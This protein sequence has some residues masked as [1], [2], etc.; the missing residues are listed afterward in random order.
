MFK[1]RKNRDGKAGKNPLASRVVRGNDRPT[2]PLEDDSPTRPRAE[3]APRRSPGA[4][5]PRSA[6]G[7]G[8]P[9]ASQEPPTRLVTAP[10]AVDALTCSGDDPPVA[11]LLVVSGPGRGALVP[12]GHGMS[13]IGRG[14]DARIRVNFGD[15]QIARKGHAILTYD[16]MGR[17]FYLQHGGGANL[18]YVDGHPV[19]EPVEL[20]DEARLRL[21][22]TEFLFRTLLLP[23]VDESGG[24]SE[25][26]P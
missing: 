23:H 14:A 16:A 25:T 18:T 15:R 6:T 10:G 24:P 21:G 4:P 17:R 12:V 13:P 19:L 20:A 1:R 11:V 7:P 8:F 2:E 3:A 9:D 26:G 22:V 5:K